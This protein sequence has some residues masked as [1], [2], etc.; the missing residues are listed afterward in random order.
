M[1]CALA[2]TSTCAAY[3]CGTLAAP[4][5]VKCALALTFTTLPDGHLMEL[6]AWQTRS[7]NWAD[8]T[9]YGYRLWLSPG[10]MHVRAMH[11]SSL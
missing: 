7:Y 1:A 5:V 3:A 6:C 8:I 11:G 2:A 10:I 9:K 4:C